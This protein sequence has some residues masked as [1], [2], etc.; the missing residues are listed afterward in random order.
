MVGDSLMMHTFYTLALQLGAI[1]TIP[2]PPG[3]SAY[4]MSI[5]VCGGTSH[6]HYVRNDW[7]ELNDGPVLRDGHDVRTPWKHL[8]S[9][10][11]IIMVNQGAHMLPW[12]DYRKNV[13]KTLRFLSKTSAR[14]FYLGMS[15]G[16][17]HCEREKEPRSPGHEPDLRHAPHNWSVIPLY[18]EDTRRFIEREFGPT[19]CVRYIDLASAAMLRGDA[20]VGAHDCLHFK[21]PGVHDAWIHIIYNEIF[22]M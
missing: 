10:F 17:P 7:L 13:R 18:N 3:A 19:R 15:P 20:H 4:N 22:F 2:R 14:V 21:F 8:V 5:A 1:D 6:V 12:S 9:H 11:D 16:F